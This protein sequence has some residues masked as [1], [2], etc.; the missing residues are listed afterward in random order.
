M[1]QMSTPVLTSSAAAAISPYEIEHGGGDSLRILDLPSAEYHAD[2]SAVSCSMLKSLLVSPAHFQASLLA[3]PKPSDAKDFGSLLH[4]LLL[5]PHVVGSEVAVYPGIGH[6]R[7]KDYKQFCELNIDRMVVDEPT[8]ARARRLRE[9]VL[10]AT[11]KGRAIGRFL[12]ES[13]TEVSYYYTDKTTGQRIRCRLDIEHPDVT[14]DLKSTRHSQPKAFVND[15]V[16]MD[17]DLQAYMYS[18]ARFAFGGGESGIKPFVFI[19][20]ETAEPFSVSCITAGESVLAN[21]HKKYVE[22]MSVLKACTDAQFWPDLGC[23]MTA[24]ITYW[25]EFNGKDAAWKA[26]LATA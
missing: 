4:M 15:I 23:E 10:D 1:N 12:E 25:Q 26:G 19:P 5:E 6:G 20:A 21:G 8:F 13:M 24:E 17:Y 3:P 9:K 14:F 11:Y 2:R 16:G 22:C 18:V 7:D